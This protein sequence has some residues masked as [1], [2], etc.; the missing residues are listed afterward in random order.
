MAIDVVYR[1]CV[2]LASVLQAASSDPL[3]IPLSN[4][5]EPN[6]ALIAVSRERSE[7]RALVHTLRTL[8]AA[9]VHHTLQN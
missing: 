5:G 9:D 6:R 3:S 8:V 4:F 2:L 1:V 7:A